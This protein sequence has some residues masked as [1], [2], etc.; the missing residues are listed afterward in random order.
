MSSTSLSM[1]FKEFYGIKDDDE[2]PE[3]PMDINS[4]CFD[5]KLLFHQ[6]SKT[7]SIHQLVSQERSLVADI[8]SLDN[9]MQTLVYDNYSKFLN[10]SDVVRTFGEKI[11]SLTNQVND[12]EK[13]LLNVSEH[14]DAICK[15]LQG[16]REKIQR[17]IGIQRLLERIEFISKLPEKLRDCLKKK[18][19]KKAVDIWAKVEK[20]LSTQQHFPSFQRIHK[21]CIEIMD[22]VE[23]KIN[24]EMLTTDISV[25]KSI[26]YGTLLLRFGVSLSLICSQLAHHRFLVVDNLIEEMT[27][28]PKEPFATLSYINEHVISDA[29][30]FI[31]L[32][33]K[34][35]L[36][37]TN[38]DNE[39]PNSQSDANKLY[40][41]EIGILSNFTDNVFS[42]LQPIIPFE[43]VFDL[44]CKKLAAY[45]RV[46]ADLFTPISNEQV[47]QRQIH[48]LIKQYTTSRVKRIYEAAKEIIANNDKLELITRFK[49]DFIGSVDNIIN[50]YGILSMLE[51][52]ECTQ[53]LIQEISMML[54]TCAKELPTFDEKKCLSLSIISD[55]FATKGINYI[56]QNL[57]KIESDVP[58]ATNQELAKQF[59]ITSEKCIL[60]Y[61]RMERFSLE[62]LCCAAFEKM[63]LE[64]TK[65]P[66]EISFAAKFIST[67][68]DELFKTFK[69][70]LE[71]TSAQYNDGTDSSTHRSFMG[72][73]IKPSFVGMRDETFHHIDRLFTS[74]NRLGLNKC[75]KLDE[76]SLLSSVLFYVMKSILEK[77]R[78]EILTNNSFHQIQ[79]DCYYLYEKFKDKMQQKDFYA[80]LVEEI[81]NS[82]A[83]RTIDSYPIELSVLETIYKSTIQT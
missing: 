79:I 10:A 68:F 71:H 14:N 55:Y 65:E 78:D 77:L 64:S 25:E 33:K 22:S 42:R 61:V 31:E 74:L 69:E 20:I 4:S 41:K 44:D 3:N 12:L 76:R 35:L 27:D 1:E 62:E 16:N 19:Y 38:N 72:S 8:M 34:N 75:P 24:E 82:A 51:H 40:Q 59:S 54:T 7:L 80:I 49:E 46:Y 50:E 5:A 60:R 63:L 56:F 9:D 66:N 2:P 81:I 57:M 23:G 11:D 13:T 43:P 52:K 6:S 18:K 47:I 53:I 48:I 70:V 30:K 15:E 28:I 73:S 29:T 37:I 36:N 83:E 45:L 39:N 58:Q 32:Y 17:L 67:S 26:L 21:E